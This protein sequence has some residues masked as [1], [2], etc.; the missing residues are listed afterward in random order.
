MVEVRETSGGRGHMLPIAVAAAVSAACFAAYWRTHGS[1]PYWQDSGLFLAALKSGGGLLSPGYP[2]YLLL[3]RPFVWAFETLLP[4]RT[5]AE[6]GNTFSA[7]WAALAAGLTCLSIATLLRPGYRFF[8]REPAPAKGH[9]GGGDLA[10]GRLAVLAASAL[11]GLLA[12]LSYSLWFQALTAEA[13]ALNAFFAAL[14]VFLLLRLGGEGRLGPAP[15]PRQTRL[16]LALLAVHGLSCGNH[17]VTVVFLPALGWLAWTQ[18][19]ALRDRRLLITAVSVYLATAFLPYLYLPWAAT[20]YPLTPFSHVMRPGAL[21]SH[22][23]GTQWTGRGESFG[24]DAS[25]F[26]ELPVQAWREMFGIGLLGLLLGLRRLWR[27]QRSLFGLL[28]LVL[29][30][31]VLLPIFYLR[32][33]EYD[34]WLLP[35]LLACFLAAGLGVETLLAAILRAHAPRLVR[36]AGALLLAAAALG[37]SLAVNPPL[38]DRRSDYTPEDFGRNLYR[39]LEPNAILIA[40]SDQENALT[41]YLEVVEGLRPDVIRIDAGSVATPWFADWVKRRYP[42]LELAGA[43]SGPAATTALADWL[44]A[45]VRANVARRPIYA[46]GR[47]GIRLPAGFEWVPS[48]GLFKTAPAGTAIDPADW[49]YSY[50]SER[51]FDRPARRHAPELQAD[52]TTR[53]EPYTA[54]IRRFHVQAWLNLAEWSVESGEPA[55]A[56]RAYS[57]ALALDPGLAEPGLLFGFGKALF[58]TDQD[59]EAQRYLERASGKLD[60]PRTVELSLY[61]GQILARRGDWRAAEPY[62]AALRRLAPELWPQLQASLR[63]RGLS[64]PEPAR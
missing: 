38:L 31:A 47:P 16:L 62:F 2:V 50:R 59:D 5:F 34:F 3:G 39:H 23:L 17:P 48:G 10:T 22:M 28:G 35:F 54:Q 8:S 45:I 11:G 41:Y 18:R 26:V 12:G 58:L 1:G 56:V 49:E 25:R 44:E 51:P 55:R 36:A 52:G 6:A 4:G 42:D 29:L 13:Y 30:P 40:S 57:E 37:P 24:L 46:S 53:R 33:G 32:G 19:A 63:E 15:A 9:G 21:L 7:V 60:V 64:P 27:E 43:P 20:A 61:L 14:L